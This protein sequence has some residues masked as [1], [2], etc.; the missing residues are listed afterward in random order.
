MKITAIKQAVKD[1][2]RAHIYVDDE[3]LFTLYI[4]FII[5]NGL[6]IGLEISE[7]DVEKLKSEDA[8]KKL[9]NKSLSFI[10]RRQRSE[11]EIRDYLAKKLYTHKLKPED[12][13]LEPIID[14]LKS[15]K[16]IDDEEFAKLWINSR[17]KKGVGP[18]KLF[19]ELLQKGVNKEIINP[20]LDEIDQENSDEAKEKLIAKYTK[21][22]IFKSE[23]EKKWKVGGYLRSKGF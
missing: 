12:V 13:D 10:A 20:L 17:I 21:N 14:K 5:E 6:K 1:K 18:K 23:S 7:D 11:K 15:Y 3:Y 4:D 22:K 8:V 9:Y 16:F 19:L 2:N